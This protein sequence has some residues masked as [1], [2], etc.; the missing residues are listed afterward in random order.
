MKLSKQSVYY[1]E[2]YT[3]KQGQIETGGDDEPLLSGK[4]DGDYSEEDKTKPKP[5]IKSKGPSDWMK[6]GS[7]YV[8]GGIYMFV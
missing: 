6:D 8:H 4:L 7:F 3:K 2:L 5:V 1:N